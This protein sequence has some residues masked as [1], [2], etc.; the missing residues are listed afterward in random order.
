M[1][2]G[3]NFI[4]ITNFKFFPGKFNKGS[5]NEQI[6]QQHVAIKKL[7]NFARDV[8]IAG[9][10]VQTSIYRSFSLSRNKK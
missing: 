7:K 3:K 1:D 9:H 6:S 4:S 8:W 2:Y 5:F 10:T